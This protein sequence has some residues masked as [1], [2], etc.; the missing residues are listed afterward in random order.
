MTYSSTPMHTTYPHLRLAVYPRLDYN[1]VFGK[2]AVWR[3][4]F[5]VKQYHSYIMC[6]VAGY[7]GA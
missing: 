3:T 2:C 4:R 1:F 7:P 6:P 5:V